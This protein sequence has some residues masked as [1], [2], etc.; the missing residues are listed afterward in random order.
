M[1]KRKK[2]TQHKIILTVL[3]GGVMST[4]LL[5]SYR[6]VKS[7]VESKRLIPVVSNRI[8]SRE[9]VK[10]SDIVMIEVP[11]H[12]VLD[13]VIDKREEVI[14]MYIKPY[15]TLVE[16]SLF[17]RDALVEESKMND[18]ALFSL[19]EGEVAISIDADIQRSY[20]NSIL[21]GHQIDLYYL[22]SARKNDTNQK[23]VLHGEIV[24]NARVLAVKDR[25]GQSIEG[26][27]ELKTAMIVVALSYE[28]AHLVEVA[29]VLGEV[30]PVISYDNFSQEVHDD[31][32]DSNKI[33]SILLGNTWNVIVEPLEVTEEDE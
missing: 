33:R 5:F 24:K 21:V 28:N 9:K 18:V 19:K 13:G 2:F 29:K 22:G 1:G 10:E 8:S 17:Y 7:E 3:V 4:T 25:D 27:S 23:E 15:H 14:G 6:Q 20:A 12:L 11:K 16:N 26:D 31:Y 30:Y 32:Y